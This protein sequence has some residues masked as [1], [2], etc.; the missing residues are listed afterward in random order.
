MSD[1]QLEQLRDA[2]VLML[3]VGGVFTIDAKDASNI[4]SEIE[5]RVV[6]PMH[7]K[8]PG[9]KLNI[10]GVEKFIKEESIKPE[11]VEGKLKITKK[12]LPSEETRLIVFNYSN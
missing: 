7:Y 8:L 12:D 6:I 2:D 11:E 10:D 1:E 9:L 3:P 4:I 5:P